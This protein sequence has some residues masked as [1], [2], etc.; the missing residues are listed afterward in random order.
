M[1]KS[2]Y[3][4]QFIE[5]LD[6][7]FFIME[8]PSLTHRYISPSVER[9]FG[10]TT[11]EIYSNPRILYKNSS[12]ALLEHT[13]NIVRENMDKPPFSVEYQL[14]TKRG[15]LRW[16][17]NSMMALTTKEGEQ[18][19]VGLSRDITDRKNAE[20]EMQ[21]LKEAYE[22]LYNNA[23]N[24]YHSIDK[25]S[26]LTRINDT[27]LKL[28]GY[29][30]EELIG[31][32][33]FNVL[34]TP[35]GRQE[36]LTLYPK[37]KELGYVKD[38]R[39][40]MVRKD[41]SV[42]PGLINAT[43][44]KDEKGDLKYTRTI[45]T[46]I[47]EQVKME[48]ALQRTQIAL[49]AINKELKQTN[50]QLERLNFTKDV[51][52]KIITNDLRDPIE[53]IK[54]VA[55]LLNEKYEELDSETVLK[56]L[57]YIQENSNHATDILEDMAGM[58]KLGGD[59]VFQIKNTDLCPIIRETIEINEVNAARKG[60][61]LLYKN[62]LDTANF[63]AKVDSKWLLRALNNLMNN[64]IKSSTSG[65]CISLS[66]DRKGNKVVIVIEENMV[67][68]PKEILTKLLSN[69]DVPNYLSTAFEWGK[70]SGLSI[71]KK[72]IEMQAGEIS[73]ASKEGV[74]SI[75]EIRFTAVE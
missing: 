26:V 6:E 31:K 52:L 11:E 10:Y 13:I 75:F 42:V 70:G 58:I 54:L 15:E 43:L 16:F 59:I 67:G 40:D 30:R 4:R 22:D 19:L 39:I 27:E 61:Q 45:F 64:V 55:N 60:I 62:H 69:Y 1:L 9:F 24:S 20:F 47:S 56:Y 53:T 74:G 2:D 35:K 41:G 12:P 14:E 7:I 32:Q 51:L 36:F 66:C 29:S 21:T 49:K 3:F 48:E 18:L 25:N 63:R 65:S 44:V 46:D 71:V 8:F 33:N 72:I 23:P 38:Y 50:K 28:L 73:V 68:A 57:E 37:F 17:M 34:F 5:Q